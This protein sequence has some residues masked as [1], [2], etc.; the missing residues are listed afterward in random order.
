M[1]DRA[2]PVDDV[3]RARRDVGS[4]ARLPVASDRWLERVLVRL[5]IEA[6]VRGAGDV[7]PSSARAA[8][9]RILA[10]YATPTA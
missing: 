3:E 4:I 5:G 6:E 1:G 2:Y 10:R 9:G 7:W 8:A